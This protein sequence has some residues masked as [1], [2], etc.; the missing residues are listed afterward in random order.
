MAK[1]RQDFELETGLADDF[2]GAISNAYFGVDARYAEV[3]GS[4]DP[5]LTLVLESPDLEQPA[6]QRYSCGA[7]KKWQVSNG[8]QEIVSETRPDSHIFN[9]SSRAGVLVGRMFEL[10]GNGDKEKGR[11]FFIGRD[12]YMTQGD[13][14]TGL[15]FHWKRQ[16]LKTVGGDTS[17]VLMP[18]RY[19]GAVKVNGAKAS[20]TATVDTSAL[21]SIVIDEVVKSGMIEREVKQAAMKNETLKA[22]DAYMRDLISGPRLADL[23]K[24]G[25]LTRGPDGKYI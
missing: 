19:I 17:D 6:Q 8:G 7:A 24:E 13:F 1:T 21:D 12:H 3:S 25:K 18:E 5:M 9:M 20:A 16:A 14:Y 23:E 22:N 11:D 15:N 2:D 4:S 10:I